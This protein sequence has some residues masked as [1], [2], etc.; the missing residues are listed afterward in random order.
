[1]LVILGLLIN[2]IFIVRFLNSNRNRI[3]AVPNLGDVIL[4]LELNVGDIT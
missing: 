1:M 3:R 4:K 2:T